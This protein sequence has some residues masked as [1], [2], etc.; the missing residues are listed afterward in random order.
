MKKTIL[1][2]G[3]SAIVLQACSY[4]AVIDTSGRSGTFNESRAENLTND[5][6]LCDKLAKENSNMFNNIGHWILSPE[7]DTRYRHIYKTC[8]NNRGHSILY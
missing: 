6:L 7:M 8:L 3:L 2:L 4:H 1:I 5:M